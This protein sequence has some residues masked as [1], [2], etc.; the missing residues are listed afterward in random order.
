[1]T[2]AE[3][4]PFVHYS[5]NSYF[6]WYEPTKNYS[7]KYHQV[8]TDQYSDDKIP[9]TINC[10]NIHRN[11][12]IINDQKNDSVVGDELLNQT[13]SSDVDSRMGDRSA[14]LWFVESLNGRALFW[15]SHSVNQL[16]LAKNITACF[17]WVY[18]SFSLLSCTR[19]IDR[20]QHCC[21][22]P[23]EHGHY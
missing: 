21:A 16:E 13:L 23:Q 3:I 18:H 1:M 9:T 12:K 17:A 20:S 15:V 4:L 6:A 2:K 5:K 10:K 22:I 14:I 11:V 8:L 7:K 19:K